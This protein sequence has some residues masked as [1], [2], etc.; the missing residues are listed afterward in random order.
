MGLLSSITGRFATDVP[1]LVPVPRMADLPPARLQSAARYLSTLDD[2]GE[3]VVARGLASASTCR[4]S[5]SGEALEVVRLA[6]SFRILADALRGATTGASFGGK[7]IRS[8]LVVRWEHGG[9]RWHTGFRLEDVEN[10]KGVHTP[11]PDQWVRTISKMA[12]NTAGGK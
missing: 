4:L 9:Q 10:L 7:P 2:A 3:K 11:D 6:G 8:L 1:A 12:S 5:I